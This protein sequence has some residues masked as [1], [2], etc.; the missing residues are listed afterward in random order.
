MEIID[1][2]YLALTYARHELALRGVNTLETQKS[3]GFELLTSSLQKLATTSALMANH[4]TTKKDQDYNYNFWEHKLPN[5]DYDFLIC[6]CLENQDG[7]VIENGW[8][9]FPK[10]VLNKLGEKNTINIFESDISGNYAREPKIN[11]NYYFKNWKILEEN[12]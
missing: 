11:K 7:K 4:K 5:G 3:L 1:R 9:I 8:F 2:S 6:V 10:S 12:S